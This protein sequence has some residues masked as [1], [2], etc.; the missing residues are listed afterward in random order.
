MKDVKTLLWDITY[1]CNLRCG[2]CY[3]SKKID[4][5]KIEITSHY[6]ISELIHKIAKL[7]VT[8]IHLL[9]GEPFLSNKLFE[10]LNCAHR[11]GI[12]TTINTNGT[13]LTQEI[14]DKLANTSLAQIAISLDGGD[15]ETNDRVRGQGVF[16][17]VLKNLQ[18]LSTNEHKFLIQLTTVATKSNIDS[19]LKL[20]H[21]AK[22]YGIKYLSVLSLYNEGRAVENQ[23][24]LAIT[25][26]EYITVIKKLL[27]LGIIYDVKIY[28][29][30]KPLVLKTIADKYNLKVDTGSTFNSC[31]AFDTIL[32]MDAY[33]N[34]YPCGPLSQTNIN[35]QSI[36]ITDE[37]LNNKIA[38]CKE[39][40]N[41]Y[42]KCLN[43]DNNICHN[44]AYN[45]DCNT[46]ILCSAKQIKI[47]QEVLTN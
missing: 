26:L 42:K 21:L 14:I 41:E 25:E 13:F 45:S 3:N 37:D 22:K 8:H 1:K 7:G 32:Y 11:L 20:P 31:K 35:L 17:K 34:I 44:C 36:N 5:L 46:C 43:I 40:F 2:H 28:F 9:G 29:D 10:I 33:G 16:D 19:I 39:S 4:D 6:C 23:N 27:L 18:Y 15:A 12:E 30:C 47:C 38:M 24:S